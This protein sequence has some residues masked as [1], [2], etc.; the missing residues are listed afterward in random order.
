MKKGD[1]I[2]IHRFSVGHSELCHIE[3][4]M[5]SIYDNEK[6]VVFRTHTIKSGWKYYAMEKG[7]FE[8][9]K[10]RHELKHIEK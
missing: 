4:V 7:E 6:I 10:T 8:F 9:F 1:K 5:D 2:R 3:A